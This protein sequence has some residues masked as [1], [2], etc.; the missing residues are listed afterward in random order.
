VTAGPL[1]GRLIAHHAPPEVIA[2]QPSVSNSVPSRRFFPGGA[3]D[4]QDHHQ[5]RNERFDFSITK[6]KVMRSVK[7]GVAI[8]FAGLLAACA[9]TSFV[10]PAGDQL[11]LGT[12]TKNQ[13]LSLMGTPFIHDQGV[14]KREK[15]EVIYYAYAASF[16][17]REMG[18]LFHNDVLVGT[19]FSSQFKEDGTYFDFQKAASV[20]QGM[21]RLEVESLLGRAGG[22]Y[23]Y[24]L[25][26]G[27]SGKSLV[28]K[29]SETKVSKF[30][31]TMLVVELD[32]RDVVQRSEPDRFVGL[33]GKT[34]PARLARLWSDD[35][36]R[37]VENT[38]AFNAGWEKL[39]QGMSKADVQGL[40]EKGS[41]RETSTLVSQDPATKV[42]TKVSIVLEDHDRD[43]FI[44]FNQLRLTKWGTLLPMAWDE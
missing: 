44:E 41:C 39:R 15:I 18:F 38:P 36:R 37:W 30:R 42:T 8:I 19:E 10:K 16:L 7:A 5:V 23:R 6:G 29:F 27:K 4:V 17:Q 9:S 35:H 11:I 2:Q 13:I 31:R 43:C 14:A 20:K 32:D 1:R 25:V 28:Y 26:S 40:L 33:I 22:E 34:R 12:T 21:T 3:R 24:P